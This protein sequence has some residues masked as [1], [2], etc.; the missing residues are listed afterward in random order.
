MTPT[1]T[2]IVSYLINPRTYTQSYTPT[3]VQGGGGGV[4][5]PLPWVSFAVLQY[6][7][8]ILPVMWS[9]E[10]VNI[11]GCGAAGGPWRHLEWPPRWPPS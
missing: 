7:E 4:L 5:Q 1:S 6:L 10:K 8:N 3:V 11:M 2:K 9:T